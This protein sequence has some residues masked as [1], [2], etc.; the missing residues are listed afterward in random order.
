MLVIGHRE[1]RARAYRDRSGGA[2]LDRCAVGTCG[3]LRKLPHPDAPGLP[4]FRLH[5]RAGSTL[6]EVIVALTILA[7]AGLAAVTGTREAMHAVQHA[8][9]ADRDRIRASAFLEVVA[10]WPREDLDQRLGDRPQGPWRL[11]I[12]R[13]LP[14]LYEVTLSDSARRRA[15]LRTSLYRPEASDAG[16]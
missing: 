10:L 14:T 13:P 2:C 12:D 3:R 4:S 11:R 7:T 5:G 6:L 16:R 1:A 9:E 15:I 8:R